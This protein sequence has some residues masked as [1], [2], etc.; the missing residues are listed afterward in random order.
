LVIVFSMPAAGVPIDAAGQSFRGGTMIVWRGAGALVLAIMWGCSLTANLLAEVLSGGSDYWDTH[1]WPF[2]T[3]MLAAAPIIWC[4]GTVLERRA[5]AAADPSAGGEDPAASHEFFFV[6]M[7]YWG[8][9]ALAIGAYCL[10]ANK[11]PGP[12]RTR[13]AAPAVSHSD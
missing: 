2:A 9:V 6:R 10:A 13:A 12:Y 11:A 7:K 4:V 8:V 3:A 1:A 5:R